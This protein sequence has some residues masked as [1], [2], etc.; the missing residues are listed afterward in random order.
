[1]YSIYI[2]IYIVYIDTCRLCLEEKHL[3]MMNPDLGTLN[4]ED[5][6]YASC[7]HRGPLLLSKFLWSFCLFF[8][9]R[10]NHD[11]ICSHCLFLCLSDERFTRNIYVIN[12][13]NK[14]PAICQIYCSPM[15]GEQLSTLP[16]SEVNRH[17]HLRNALSP[18]NSGDRGLSRP[19]H[20]AEELGDQHQQHP[21]LRQEGV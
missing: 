18:I 19:H 20:G 9:V 21:H 12:I 1:M 14:L 13:K 4:V 7:R 11:W 8:L 17:T 10:H 3:L 5:E 2:Y 15:S 6:F 16:W